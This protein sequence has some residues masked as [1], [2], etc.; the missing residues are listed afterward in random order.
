M[1]AATTMITDVATTIFGMIP[2]ALTTVKSEPLLYIPFVAP[3]I[4]IPLAVM[5]KLKH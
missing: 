4:A 5:R 3:I 2:T 1:E